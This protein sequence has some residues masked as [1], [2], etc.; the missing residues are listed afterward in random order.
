MGRSLL[1]LALL[2]LTGST[3][4]FTDKKA[5]AESAGSVA[6]AIPLMAAAI[7]AWASADGREPLRNA[8]YNL[9][10]FLMQDGSHKDALTFLDRALKIDPRR[11]PVWR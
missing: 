4:E 11:T 8:C 10:F 3:S 6:K 1:L 7:E 2:A 5:A 9:A